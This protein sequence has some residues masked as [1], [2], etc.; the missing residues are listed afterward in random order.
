MAT[1]SDE[2]FDQHI[3]LGTDINVT[4]KSG[5]DRRTTIQK[6]AVANLQS[7][8]SRVQELSIPLCKT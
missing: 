6:Y 7:T 3:L 4:T 2:F 1:P 8:I 5:P